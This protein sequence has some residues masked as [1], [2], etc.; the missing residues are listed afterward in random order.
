MK[1]IKTGIIPAKPIIYKNKNESGLNLKAI[2]IFAATGFF[3]ERDTYFNNFEALQPSTDN[4]I[5]D[6]NFIRNSTQNWHWHYTP[7]AVSLKQATEEFAHLFENISNNK[8]KNKKIILPL[9]G[10]LDSRTQAA[11]LGKEVEVKSYSYKFSGSF[12]ETKYGK[13]ISEIKSFPFTEYVIPKGYLWKVIDEL[14]EMNQCYADFTH[15]RQM[16]VI[17]EVSKLGE[18]FYLGHWGD[19]LFDDMGVSDDLSTEGQID[20]LMQKILKRGGYELADELWRHWGIEGNF[21]NYLSERLSQLLQT[22]NIDNANSRIRAFKSIYWAPRWTSANMIV[23]SHYHPVVLPYYDDEMCKFICTVPEH[24]LSGR[25]I[26]IS[27]IK[28]KNPELAKIEWQTYD[29]LNLYNYKKF[30]SKGMIPLRAFRKGKRLIKEKIFRHKLTTRNWEIQFMGDEND[31]NLRKHLFE[32]KFFS[33][34]ISPD[35]VKNFYNKFKND[36]PVYYSHPLSMLLTLSMFCKINLQK[37][38]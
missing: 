38:N 26:Q 35:L 21:K 2:C 1:V 17:E 18:I 8:L 19:V 12:D 4:E 14:A 37:S 9:S 28:L 5:D 22:I 27:Y 23:F 15:P 16:A 25:Q 20:V 13:K 3:L 36:D 24:L 33:E 34:F 10:G 29:P 31:I 11:A 6:E 7:A 30:T 32:T